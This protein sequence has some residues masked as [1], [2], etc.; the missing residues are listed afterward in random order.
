MGVISPGQWTLAAQ[1]FI[2]HVFVEH[3][4]AALE[5][6]R[7]SQP[8]DGALLTH[9][10]WRD[11]GELQQGLEASLGELLTQLAARVRVCVEKQGW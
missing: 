11:E 10:V 4:F 9:A 1:T 8:R 6:R 7:H 2:L 3:V 5:Q